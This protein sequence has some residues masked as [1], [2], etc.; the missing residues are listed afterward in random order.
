M[1]DWLS[2]AFC[3]VLAGLASAMLVFSM[4]ALMPQDREPVRME[5]RL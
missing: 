1:S 4:A 3:L 5:A 2:D